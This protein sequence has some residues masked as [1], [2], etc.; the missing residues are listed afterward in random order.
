MKLAETSKSTSFIFSVR[1]QQRFQNT[2]EKKNNQRK[3]F[4]SFFRMIYHQK[5]KSFL[6]VMFSFVDICMYSFQVEI[7]KMKMSLSFVCSIF[8]F[9][10]VVEDGI[11]YKWNCKNSRFYDGWG[12]VTKLA[13]VWINNRLKGNEERIYWAHSNKYTQHKK[14]NS[15]HF[16]F[17]F[18]CLSFE[19]GRKK[20]Y[21]KMYSNGI[22]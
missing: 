16:S 8:I 3:C 13:F 15:N 14:K 9:S 4:F 2:T 18:V 7:A 21:I 17:S 1:R 10:F 5:V 19:C 20:K 12:V 11:A 22:N 6:F